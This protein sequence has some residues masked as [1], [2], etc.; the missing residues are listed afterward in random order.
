MSHSYLHARVLRF[1]PDVAAPVV[2]RSL[3]RISGGP[4]LDSLTEDELFKLRLLSI[5]LSLSSTCHGPD[6]PLHN[7]HTPFPLQRNLLKAHSHIACRAH[8]M[9]FR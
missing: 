3:L 6:N 2:G 1:T 5:E 7:L 9:P 4:R 8:A